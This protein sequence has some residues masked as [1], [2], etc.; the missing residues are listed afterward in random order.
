MQVADAF[1]P[2]GTKDKVIIEAFPGVS[3]FPGAP[4]RLD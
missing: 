4:V 2:A 1:V 3:N